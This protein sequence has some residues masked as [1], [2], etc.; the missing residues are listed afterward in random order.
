[1]AEKEIKYTKDKKVQI[2][3]RTSKIKKAKFKDIVGDMSK[4]LN[5]HISDTI[6]NH[7]NN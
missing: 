2:I 3:V 6:E 7:E 4:N 1:M 5:E